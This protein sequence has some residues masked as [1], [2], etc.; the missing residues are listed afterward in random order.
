[1]GLAEIKS[2][3]EQFFLDNWIDSPID[4]NGEDFEVPTDK[5]Y[6]SL[7]FIP[8]DRNKYAFDGTNGRSKDDT[9]LKV[10][11]YSNNPQKSFQLQ[12]KVILFLEDQQF[13]NTYYRIAKPDGNGAVDFENDIYET[14]TNFITDTWN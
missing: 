7:Q 6:I 4:W 14:T 12:D 8:F 2:T 11:S 1:M 3:V 5:E 9:M 10:R 13:G